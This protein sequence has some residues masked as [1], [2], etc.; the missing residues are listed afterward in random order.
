M[1]TVFQTAEYKEKGGRWAPVP[2]WA[3]YLIKCGYG[4]PQENVG[5][6]IAFISLPYPCPA[7]GL[8]TLGAMIRLLER[9]SETHLEKHY[10]RLRVSARDQSKPWIVKNSSSNRRFILSGV[11]PILGQECIW[12]KLDDGKKGE[13]ITQKNCARW[14][15]D[16]EPFVLSDADRIPFGKFYDRLTTYHPERESNFALS[17]ANLWLTTKSVGEP[18]TRSDLQ[19]VKFRVD[20]TGATLLELLSVIGWKE[21]NRFAPSRVVLFNT[22]AGRADRDG[23]P[24]HTVIVDGPIPFLRTRYQSQLTSSN[25]LVILFRTEERATLEETA[26]QIAELK[27]WY[28]PVRDAECLPE[29]P[30]SI[31]TLILRRKSGSGSTDRDI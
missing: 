6:T 25:M 8:I 28:T 9:P 4:W 31:Q 11:R 29:P 13:A 1:A 14:R 7:A 2:T 24:P 27:R 26:A 18:A 30:A 15:F 21:G 20:G 16:E 17:D 23:P 10:N 3:N 5:R 12:A 22:L 19:Q